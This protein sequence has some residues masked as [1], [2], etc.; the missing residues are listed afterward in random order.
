MKI[1]FVFLSPNFTAIRIMEKI[2]ENN[3]NAVLLMVKC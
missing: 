2:K 3:P 1:L